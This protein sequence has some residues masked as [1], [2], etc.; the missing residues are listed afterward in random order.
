[1]V[2]RMLKSEFIKY[3]KGNQNVKIGLYFLCCSVSQ[4][5]G[6]RFFCTFLNNYTKTFQ[7][8]LI[9]MSWLPC[10]MLVSE[11]GVDCWVPAGGLGWGVWFSGL[12][13]G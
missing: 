12:S 7:A 10:V 1:M 2:T 11:F 3:I 5:R 6:G 9:F 13:E 8:N 4:L